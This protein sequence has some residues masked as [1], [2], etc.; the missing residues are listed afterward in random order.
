MGK[1]QS[2]GKHKMDKMK[3]GDAAMPTEQ[4]MEMM[5]K[6]LEMMEQMMGQMIGHT[7]EKSKMLHKHK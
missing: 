5:E 2:M 3:K 6:R 7:A 1:G 4:K